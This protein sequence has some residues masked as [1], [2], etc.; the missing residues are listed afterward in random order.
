[1]G[2]AFYTI[3]IR[4]DDGI[5]YRVT[6][7]SRFNRT[8]QLLNYTLRGDYLATNYHVIDL[9]NVSFFSLSAGQHQVTVYVG[10]GV[11][12]GFYVYI[13]SSSSFVTNSQVTPTPTPSSSSTFTASLAES[14]SSIYLGNTVNF[15]VTVNGGK[16]PYRYNWN[17]DNQT[18][19]NT[20]VPYFSLSNLGIGEHHVFVN[21][22][23]ANNN[24]ATTLTVA[25]DVLPNPN[26]SPSP[27]PSVPEISYWIAIPLVAVASII[28][29]YICRRRR[30]P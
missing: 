23:D 9:Y 8:M 12:D 26:S 21:V 5:I 6:E 4:V 27:S 28:I 10:N 2:F 19:G 11:G 3:G 25:F 1:M 15:T 24:T 22:V 14:A 17:L 13:Y 7:S 20:T 18:A 30:K 16:E 29:S